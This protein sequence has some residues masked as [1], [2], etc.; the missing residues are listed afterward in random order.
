MPAT[1]CRVQPF[2][3]VMTFRN[4]RLD[5]NRWVKPKSPVKSG[6]PHSLR[7]GHIENSEIVRIREHVIVKNIIR[8]QVAQPAHLCAGCAG[9]VVQQ[10]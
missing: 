6:V 8:L 2:L 10:P 3:I 7:H 9:R 1:T 5:R 4:R